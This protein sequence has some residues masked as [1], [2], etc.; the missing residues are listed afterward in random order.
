MAYSKITLSV[1][2]EKEQLHL[3]NR[4][5]KLLDEAEIERRKRNGLMGQ[6]VD[7]TGE[8]G[9]QAMKECRRVAMEWRAIMEELKK[10]EGE[11]KCVM[12][13]KGE[14]GE[15]GGERVGKNGE[16]LARL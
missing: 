1:H 3:L 16:V 14:E 15:R 12:E 5:G 13:M 6:V 11:I 9:V 2:R 7:M 4:F 10:V 8:E